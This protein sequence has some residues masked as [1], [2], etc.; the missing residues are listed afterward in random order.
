MASDDRPAQAITMEKP[1][2]EKNYLVSE[3]D[4]M[5]RDFQPERNAVHVYPTHRASMPQ[6]TETKGRCTSRNTLPRMGLVTA[7]L[8]LIY[9][10]D[11]MT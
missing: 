5:C 8:G 4:Q 3:S 6:T 2:Q 10:S 7:L 9:V 1:V 11:G